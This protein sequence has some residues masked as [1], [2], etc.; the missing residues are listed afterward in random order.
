[1]DSKQIN[2]NQSFIFQN[3]DNFMENLEKDSAEL[4]N[5]VIQNLSYKNKQLKKAEDFDQTGAVL[6]NNEASSANK[7]LSETF[8]QQ[9]I[10][11]Y[12]NQVLINSSSESIEENL[13]G[14]LELRNNKNEEEEKNAIR[15]YCSQHNGRTEK[16][17]RHHLKKI[18][19][20]TR[21]Q[22]ENYNNMKALTA[23]G[24]SKTSGIKSA[25]MKGYDIAIENVELEYKRNKH[26][27]KFGGDRN[28]DEES[29]LTRLRYIRYAKKINITK[30]YL[31]K[32]DT[33]PNHYDVARLNK[34]L[35]KLNSS[36]AE[37]ESGLLQNEQKEYIE[38][39]IEI[40]TEK[41]AAKKKKEEERAKTR[42]R[43]KEELETFIVPK[44]IQEYKK[45]KT[46]NEAKWID[47][48][49]DARNL[50]AALLSGGTFLLEEPKKG[51]G[52]EFTDNFDKAMPIFI[53]RYLFTL[54]TEIP[55]ETSDKLKAY[56]ITS[57]NMDRIIR[58]QLHP[59]RQL[60]D[61][62]YV[63]KEDEENDKFNQ[64]WINSFFENNMKDRKECLRENYNYLHDFQIKD[65]HQTD[66]LETDIWKKALLSRIAISISNQTKDKFGE[67]NITD[68]REIAKELMNEL[69][70]T[71]VY[72]ENEKMDY[73][74]YITRCLDVFDMYSR[75]KYNMELT[76]GR[77]CQSA[78][79]DD[80][81]FNTMMDI[82]IPPIKAFQSEYGKLQK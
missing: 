7:V 60:S 78:E 10:E 82:R 58:T 23:M 54:A 55:K 19:E 16:R 17:R 34:Q 4:D 42:K 47:E 5:S 52:A 11:R 50:T 13:G 31:E 1:M 26:I 15:D 48:K 81:Y 59:V 2:K 44:A 38:K 29:A 45:T 70:S 61:K 37:L 6:V 40:R 49:L 56:N 80:K 43:K 18:D 79:V 27:L 69:F 21:Q 65:I 73:T 25:N 66:F 46:G 35:E 32:A 20:Y 75:R 67:G 72:F 68:N 77:L 30:K 51:A 57:A 71:K 41:E 22:S 12:K 24:A 74:D 63:S 3:Y 9:Y 76:M 36:I 28:H 8:S 33:N 39:A 14:Y 64:K 62:T 53:E